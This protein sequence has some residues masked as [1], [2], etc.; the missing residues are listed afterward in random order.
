MKN[1]LDRQLAASASQMLRSST[2]AREVT[3]DKVT[4][5]PEARD[6]K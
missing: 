5:L 3:E 6:L 1:E 2:P 4:T